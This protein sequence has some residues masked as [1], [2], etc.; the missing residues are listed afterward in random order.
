MDRQSHLSQLAR[1]EL[2]DRLRGAG[3]EPEITLDVVRFGLGDLVARCRVSQVDRRPDGVV[4]AVE[5]ELALRTDSREGIR[6]NSVG[7]GADDEE[8]VRR[9][10]RL[11]IEGVLPPVRAALGLGPE[12]R[13][14]PFRLSQTDPHG[15][16]ARRWRVFGGAIQVTTDD[17]ESLIRLLDSF[18]PFPYMAQQGALP[19]FPEEDGIFWMGINCSRGAE[20]DLEGSCRVNNIEWP[21]G[22]EVLSRLPWPP[23]VGPLVFRQFLAGKLLD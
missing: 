20:G 13:V 10:V 8:A 18:P 2:A 15:R 17:P 7:V 4:S 3:G 19:L 21:L 16:N 9:A 1:V 23:G 6:E 12:E 14:Q 22:I 11:W 5:F